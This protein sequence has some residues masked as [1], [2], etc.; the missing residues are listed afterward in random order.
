MLKLGN[1]NGTE[2]DSHECYSGAFLRVPAERSG[3]VICIPFSL[4]KQGNQREFSTRCSPPSSQIF[5][6]GISPAESPGQETRDSIRFLQRHENK[7]VSMI[8]VEGERI[9][10]VDAH[11]HMGARKKLAIHQIPPIMKFM[12][13]DMLQSMDDAG[14]D[15]VVTFA[16][17][18]GEPS[19]YRETNQYI[20][21]VMKQHP[22]RIH[23]FMRLS[24]GNGP[25]D[26]LKVLD[27]GIKLG[28]KGIKI[29]PLIEHCPANDK[30]KVYPLME[31][32]QHHGLTVLFHCGLGEDASPKRIGE[33]AKDFPK[34]PI[35][36]GHSGLVEG[37]REV[38]E[39]AK[40]CE[41]VHMDSSGV[42]WL[43]FFCESISWAGPDRVLYGSDHPFNPMDWEIEKIVKHAQRHL[44]LKIEDLRLIMAGN[45]KRLLKMN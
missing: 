28:L 37:V 14:V 5:L 40:R 27:E 12:A 7:E 31:A 42:G 2:R 17:G 24:P 38:V 41:N 25:K 23:G 39:I 11:S 4:N 44:K 36:M 26:T 20:A 33:V 3:V 13:E 35:I 19:D 18:I 10:V 34:L 16:I 6:S 15:G 21:G 32:A 29:H 30:E 8:N 9:E 22:K 43:P 45:I 1:C